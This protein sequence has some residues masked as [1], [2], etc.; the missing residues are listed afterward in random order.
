[1]GLLTI[2]TD[3]THNRNDTRQHRFV[4]EYLVDRNGAG[5]AVRAGYSRRTARQIAHELPAKAP[6]AAAVQE[7]EAR[8]AADTEISRQRVIAGASCGPRTRP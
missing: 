7:R 4:R 8:I 2:P 5:A 6:V 3:G 1:M